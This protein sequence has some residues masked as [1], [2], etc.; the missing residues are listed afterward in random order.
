MKIVGVHHIQLAMPV[1]GEQAAREFYAR[2]FELPEVPKPENLLKRGGVWFESELVRIHLGVEENFRPAKKAH[3]GLL[4]EN[5]PALIQR[6]RDAGHEVI[7]DERIPG[8]LRA[9]VHDPFGN[10]IEL[11]EPEPGFTG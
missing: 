6:L 5:L 2:F 8:Y 1:G 3:P 11:M 9:Y 10:R 4:V 7:D